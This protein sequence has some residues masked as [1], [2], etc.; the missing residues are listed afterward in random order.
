M[1]AGF[2]EVC[3]CQGVK[4]APNPVEANKQK[5]HVVEKCAKKG[6]QF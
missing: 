4:I 3:F 5:N 6:G 2:S 1:L